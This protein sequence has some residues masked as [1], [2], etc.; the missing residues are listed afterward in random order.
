MAP[1]LVTGNTIVIKS[2]EE[3]PLNAFDFTELLAECDL[4]KGVFN[5]VTG[6][7]DSGALLSAHKDVG[8]IS[9]TSSIGTGVKI[10][11]TA[12]RNLTRVKCI[13]Q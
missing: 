2:S 1:A 3:T 13:R 7:R 9:F 5:L 6:G 8:L 11:E 12:S 4:P 10:M